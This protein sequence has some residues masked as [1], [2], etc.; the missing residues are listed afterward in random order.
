MRFNLYIQAILGLFSENFCQPKDTRQT[1]VSVLTSFVAVT[2]NYLII[3][4]ARIKDPVKGPA[5]FIRHTT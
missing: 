5:S 1:E 3:P 4:T 2:G